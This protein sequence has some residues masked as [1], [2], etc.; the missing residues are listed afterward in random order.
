MANELDVQNEWEENAHTLYFLKRGQ[1][2]YRGGS[3]FYTI[4]RYFKGMQQNRK[5]SSSKD[6]S[7]I[8]PVMCKDTGL[9][10]FGMKD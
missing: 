2:F 8:A 1:F 4:E 9:V 3:V 7:M 6:V 5:L 10:C